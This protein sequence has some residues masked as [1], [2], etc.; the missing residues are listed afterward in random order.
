MRNRKHKE[1]MECKLM[2]CP[3]YKSNKCLIENK[4]KEIQKIEGVVT[5][6]ACCGDYTGCMLYQKFMWSVS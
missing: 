3:F 4:D 6:G 2:A 5:I 1:H